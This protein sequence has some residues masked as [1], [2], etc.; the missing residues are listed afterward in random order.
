MFDSL[1][2]EIVLLRTV[3]GIMATYGVCTEHGFVDGSPE[4]L[5]FRRAMAEPRNGGDGGF[6]WP[7]VGTP[8]E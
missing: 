4:R 1:S 5:A 3:V 6:V 2:T 7:R 8:S